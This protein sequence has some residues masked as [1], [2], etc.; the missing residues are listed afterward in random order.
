MSSTDGCWPKRLL[1]YT[2]KSAKE[3]GELLGFE[4]VSAFSRFF[5]K[6][7][8]ESITDYRRREKRE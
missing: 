6:M 3:I 7:T 2:D 1:L 5:R 8:A 4:E